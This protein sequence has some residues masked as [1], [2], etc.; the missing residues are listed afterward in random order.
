MREPWGLVSE[1]QFA[2]N[3]VKLGVWH[4]RRSVVAEIVGAK[5]AGATAAGAE[6]AAANCVG[7]KSLAQTSRKRFAIIKQLAN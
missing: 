2:R 6:G 4:Q 7:L 3:I 1:K 5:V